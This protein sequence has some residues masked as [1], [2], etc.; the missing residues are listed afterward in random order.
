MGV[1]YLGH[2]WK[3]NDDECS[4]CGKSLQDVIEED[5]ICRGNTK[6]KVVRRLR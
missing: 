3:F 4:D 5:C 1:S 6:Y 2:C